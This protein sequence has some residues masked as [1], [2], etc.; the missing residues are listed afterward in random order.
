MDNN[1]AAVLAVALVDLQNVIAA[2]REE[3]IASLFTF[4][5]RVDK[6]IQKFI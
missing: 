4:D 6:N 5:E 1:A 3:K 2:S